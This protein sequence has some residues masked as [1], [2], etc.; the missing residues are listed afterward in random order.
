M[1]GFLIFVGAYCM[2][3]FSALV[4]F[5]MSPCDGNGGR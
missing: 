4:A 5:A 3:V 1:E 2:G